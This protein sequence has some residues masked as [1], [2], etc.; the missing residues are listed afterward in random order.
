[1]PSTM[2]HLLLAQK[3]SPKASPE[4]FI[5]NIAPD[6]IVLRENHHFSHKDILHFRNSETRLKDI[7]NLESSLD[8][9]SP[10]AKGYIMHLFLDLH[11]DRDCMQPFIEKYTSYEWVVPYRREISIAS[12]YLFHNHKALKEIWK[13]MVN[14]K[15]PIYQNIQG[16]KYEEVKEYY[17]SNYK[18]YMK[19][20]TG[21][22][23]V[24]PNDF[25]EEYTDKIAEKYLKWQG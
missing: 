9:N 18:W 24:Y 21:Q 23:K 15:N 3:V 4:F 14:Y 25:V 12:A 17:E 16:V 2:I 11:W 1:M 7:E 10:Y 6:A 22:S 5:G 20:N 13:D 19:Y 8:K